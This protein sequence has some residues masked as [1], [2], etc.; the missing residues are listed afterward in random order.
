M[1]LILK[2]T[3]I[4]FCLF[5]TTN[6]TKLSA[7]NINYYEHQMH[8]LGDQTIKANYNL[9]VLKRITNK[10]N[11]EVD[12]SITKNNEIYLFH[13]DHNQHADNPISNTLSFERGSEKKIE[14]H[15]QIIKFDD[16][17]KYLLVANKVQLETKNFASSNNTYKL[18]YLY[19]K[20]TSSSEG[21]KLL[22]K[23]EFESFYKED[24]EYLRN[25]L[26]LDNKLHL[27]LSKSRF[28]SNQDYLDS[29]KNA[30]ENNFI[31]SFN[32]R[33]LYLFNLDDIAETVKDKEV[34]FWT[35]RDYP[36]TNPIFNFVLKHFNTIKTVNII[37]DNIDF[38]ES[39]ITKGLNQI[40]KLEGSFN[41]KYTS[42]FAS[43]RRNFL[44][45]W[46]KNYNYV[47]FKNDELYN[48]WLKSVAKKINEYEVKEGI[49]IIES[50][51]IHV[52]EKVI[53]EKIKKVYRIKTR[54]KI[55]TKLKLI[56]KIEFERIVKN[57]IKKAKED[58][59][60]ILIKG[61]RSHKYFKTYNDFKNYILKLKY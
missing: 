12:V 38:D 19:Q 57:R 46:N 21:Q 7:A 5:I 30:V 24:L 50:K 60:K 43:I 26:K 35:T 34:T 22:K 58:K 14:T 52:N 3:S 47:N 61:L 28:D 42:L 41:S 39:L 55:K 33:E 51:K 53:I 2:I 37:G 59:K 20:L 27:L 56:S 18:C 4:I 16:A 54:K 13:T 32:I 31:P 48:K 45:T 8:H 1:K 44:T 29:V 36:T 9:D 11:I 40:Q 6:Q 15:G 10:D 49:L 25:T 17:I 23:I